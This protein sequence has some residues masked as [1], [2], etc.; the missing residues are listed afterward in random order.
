MTPKKPAF[1]VDQEDM[2]LGFFMRG[3]QPRECAHTTTVRSEISGM[4]REVCT[5]CGQVSIGY[6]SD[7]VLVGDNQD[8]STAGRGV[9][10][11]SQLPMPRG[12]TTK[13]TSQPT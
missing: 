6:V 10:V 11:A 12:R 9:Q 3:S 5:Q 2:T 4:S 7:H 1:P 13:G 8:P